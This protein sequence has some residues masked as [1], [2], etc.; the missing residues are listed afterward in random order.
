MDVTLEKGERIEDLQCNGLKIIQNKNYYTFTSDSVILAN[1]INLKKDDFAIEIGTGC[2]VISVLLSAKVDFKKI[3]A[4]ELQDKMAHLAEKNVLLNDLQDKIQIISDDAKNFKDYIDCY[5]DVVFSNPPYMHE[6]SL[7]KNDVK[8]IARHDSTLPLSDL[9]KIACQML[10]FGG[11]FYMTF[12]ASRC[13]E[14]I[15]TLIENGLEP[16]RM[17]FTENNRREIKLIV[18]EAVKGA[19]HGVKVLPNLVTNDIDGQ[20]LKIL[21]TRYFLKNEK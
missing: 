9:C 12:P 11:K 16:K 13:A 19:R 8:S 1:F 18:V 5:A 15:H 6:G 10:K 17:F 7:N 4:F 20:Y 3:V 14:A 2:G 21:Q